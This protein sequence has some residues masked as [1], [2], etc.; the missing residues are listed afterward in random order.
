MTTRHTFK[1]RNTLAQP[2]NDISILVHL[3]LPYQ[4]VPTNL[5]NASAYQFSMPPNYRM[6]HHLNL[7]T[8]AI[9]TIT[10]EQSLRRR[11]LV[12][13]YTPATQA[14]RRPLRHKTVDCD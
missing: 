13:L 14:L 11:L 6:D 8:I 2:R 7:F 9:A 3:I 4:R 12:R 10:L 1:R 5:S